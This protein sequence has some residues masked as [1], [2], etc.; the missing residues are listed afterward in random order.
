MMA[1]EGR[2]LPVPRPECTDAHLF[3]GVSRRVRD[4]L[5]P[6]PHRPGPGPDR[7]DVRPVP[8]RVP[9][10]QGHA[11]EQHIYPKHGAHWAI[12]ALALILFVSIGVHIS[13]LITGLLGV[14]F[15][16]A[17]LREPVVRQSAAWARGDEVGTIHA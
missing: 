15:I 16:G 17:A 14:G 11:V 5:R 13:E 2:L 12:G 4:H 9:G 3:D 6:D 7:R 1:G 8:D 10:P